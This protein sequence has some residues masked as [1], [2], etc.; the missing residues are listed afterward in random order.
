MIV[1]AD[2]EQRIADKKGNCKVYGSNLNKAI[3]GDESVAGGRDVSVASG[4][5]ESVH[6]A[7]GGDESVHVADDGNA[8]GID[9]DEPLESDEIA[10][11]TD[12]LDQ[13]ADNE[14]N[15]QRVRKRIRN[16]N[17]WK[18]N[19]RKRQRNNGLEYTSK[20]GKTVQARKTI[21]HRCGRCVNKCNDVL[22]D[23]D[24][25]IVFQNY[26]SMGDR[27]RQ[28]EYISNHVNAKAKL[29]KTVCS[30]KRK[31]TY[32]YFFT[33]RGKRIKVC[34]AVFLKTLGIGERTIAYT[35]SSKSETGQVKADKR[36]KQKPGISKPEAVREAVKSHILSFPSLESHYARSGTTRKYIDKDLNITKMHSLYMEHY[37]NDESMH[38]KESYYRNVF[39]SDFNIFHKQKK[40][41]RKRRKASTI[42]KSS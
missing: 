15:N 12:N 31:V 5:D 26:W 20:L 21:Y 34:K 1:A 33:V 42:S 29:R 25:D 32:H 28:R 24:R 8:N 41:E 4:G 19:I 40:D 39:V 16:E 22:S 13:L 36:G 30:N 38:V 37:I 2:T 10:P 23:D 18:Q 6:V 14:N 3:G 17:E 9:L 7:G 35:M 27:R 11:T